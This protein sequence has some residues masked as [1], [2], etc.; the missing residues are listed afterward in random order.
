[1]EVTI[2][3][4]REAFE[5]LA[6]HLEQ[7][8]KK[9]VAI[10]FDFYWS[11]PKVQLYDN[12]DQPTQLTMGQL[13]DDLLELQRIA[14]GESPTISYGYVWLSTILKAIGDSEVD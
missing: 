11:I 9:S 12:Y 7:Q 1:M 4:L 5:K 3:Q 8:G 6:V 10:S 2:K 14:S 13:S